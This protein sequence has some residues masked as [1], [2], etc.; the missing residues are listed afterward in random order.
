METEIPKTRRYREHSLGLAHQASERLFGL[1]Q[2]IKGQRLLCYKR[3]MLRAVQASAQPREDTFNV[4]AQKTAF[5]KFSPPLFGAISNLLPPEKILHSCNA[6][7]PFEEQPAEIRYSTPAALR[8]RIP[9]RQRNETN[10]LRGRRSIGSAHLSRGA[11][12]T[13][14]SSG[15]SEGR[16]KR[17]QSSPRQQARP[18][19]AGPHDAQT[20]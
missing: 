4:P 14:F 7:S 11:I 1:V 9:P 17:I 6:F 10:S 13:R 18:D 16:A 19:G 20:Q 12:Q 3:T 5:S 15:Y 2:T 8:V